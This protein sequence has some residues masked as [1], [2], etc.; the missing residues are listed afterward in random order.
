MSSVP[1]KEESHQDF[2]TDYDEKRNEIKL[3]CCPTGCGDGVLLRT[4]VCTR[5]N[6]S[7]NESN[8]GGIGRGSA[9]LQPATRG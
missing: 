4:G 8:D 1:R 7:L 5:W 2:W 9:L 6:Y 3:W